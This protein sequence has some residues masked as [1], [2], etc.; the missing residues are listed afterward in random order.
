MPIYKS[1][2]DNL[3]ESIAHLSSDLEVIDANSSFNDQLKFI[4]NKNDKIIKNLI[5]PKDFDQ[6][7]ARF[8]SALKKEQP[9][10]LEARM[11]TS[12][13]R[14]QWHSIRLILLPNIDGVFFIAK[15]IHQNLVQL[16]RLEKIEATTGVGTWDIDLISKEV[17]WSDICHRI[18]GTNPEQFTTQVP[19]AIE[20]FH[21]D[22][23][24]KMKS[25]VSQLMEKG[26][27]YDEEMKFYTLQRELRWVR[28]IGRA[29]IVNGQ[30]IRAFGTIEDIT[31]KKKQS[32]A[33]TVLAETFHAIVHNIPIMISFFNEKGEFEWVNPAWVDTLGWDLGS[34]IGKDVLAE[35]YPLK[36]D[37][38]EV[39]KFMLGP[40]GTW[41]DFYTT[42]RFGKTIPSSWTN[43]RLSNGKSIGIGQNIEDRKKLEQQLSHA[44]EELNTVKERL[45]LAIHAMKFGVWDW[46][47]K[48]GELV[49]DEAMY[50]IFNI[51]RSDFTGD[52]DAF[53]KSLLQEDAK[54]V[55]QE[56]EEAT[57]KKSS[58][59]NSEFK[60]RNKDGDVRVIKAAAICL[61]D[62]NGQIERMVGN[63]WDVTSKKEMELRMIH[64]SQLASL[65]EM[66]G[67]VAHEIN[68]PLA[69]IKVKS[70]LLLQMIDEPT[71]DSIKLKEGLKKVSET[72]DR[73]AKI[74]KS[75]RT[76]SRDSDLDTFE[77]VDIYKLIQDS[78]DLCY[79][80]FKNHRIKMRIEK[81]DEVLLSCRVVQIGQVILNLLNNAHDAVLNTQDP[82]ISIQY[83]VLN[84]DKIQISVTDSGHGI[85]EDVA[86]RMMNPF[87]TTKEIGKGTGLGLSISKGLVEAHG[88]Q[89]F[90]D[91]KSKNTRFVIELP[92]NQKSTRAT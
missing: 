50:S 57:S 22:H 89:L 52:F 75:L 8:N 84:T 20:F 11:L 16:K 63:N 62:K 3:E 74:V 14:F 86:N 37:R 58:E 6:F 9:S 67:G 21:P 29:E 55:S 78:T 2:F 76:F 81:S 28:T 32:E 87:F 44:N 68:N 80:K 64:S 70:D 18:H 34:M 82:W 51:N 69:I 59:F 24:E 60:I 13:N 91:A 33:S 31:E 26:I 47:L 77:T 12:N 46:N 61:Y 88:G 42:T 85:P 79:E 17:Y 36:E 39:L 23:T 66:A 45:E 71:I 5:H 40:N 53:Q 7:S 4:E 10:A 73:I 49:W 15:N 38:D 72:V 48:T 90:Y 56:I 35:F 41:K 65:G 25:L 30:V 83:S 1:L 27:P 43:I 54:R 92:L 19:N